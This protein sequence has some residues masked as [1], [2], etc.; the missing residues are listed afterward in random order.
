[1]ASFVRLKGFQARITGDSRGFDRAA[2][3]AAASTR[4]LQKRQDLLRRELRRTT[5]AARTYAKSLLSV[6]SAV[7]VLA[8]GAGLGA[9][10]TRSAEY[11]GV[12]LR[13][14]DGAG[15]L[16]ENLLALRRVAGENFVST[17]LF[18][19]S[20]LK[21]NQRISEAVAGQKQAIDGFKALGISVTDASGNLRSADAILLDF[22]KGLSDA[23][24]EAVARA[25]FVFEE[26]SSQIVPALQMA[27]RHGG[28]LANAYRRATDPTREMFE[29]SKLLGIQFND[30]QEDIKNVGVVVSANVSGPWSEL[31]QIVRDKL[32]DVMVG[33][34]RLLDGVVI[35][36]FRALA[37]NTTGILTTIAAIVATFSRAGAVL[38]AAGGV[39]AATFTK[40]SAYTGLVKGLTAAMWTLV[41]SAAALSAKFIVFTAIFQLF[42]QPEVFIKNF[43]AFGNALLDLFV[44]LGK[45]IG[46]AI[47]NA[48][49]GS[50]DEQIA[51]L[52]A[53]EAVL[54]TQLSTGRTGRGGRSRAE[55]ELRG[56]RAQIAELESET[57]GGLST[58][59]NNVLGVGKDLFLGIDNDAQN[60]GNAVKNLTADLDVWSES[61]RRAAQAR[62]DLANAGTSQIQH[63]QN[64]IPLRAPDIAARAASQRRAINM[65]RFD[66]T[67]RD[68]AIMNAERAR[69]ASMVDTMFSG[70]QIAEMNRQF[71]EAERSIISFS[72]ETRT[73][74]NPVFAQLDSNLNTFFEGILTGTT[75]AGDAFKQLAAQIAQ[76]VLQALILEPLVKSVTGGIGS[77]FGLNIPGRAAGGPV[78]ARSPYVVGERGAE[79]FVPQTSGRIVPNSEMMGGGVVIN[80]QNEF[81]LFDDTG[82]N[83]RMIPIAAQIKDE[84]T[85]GVFDAL[86]RPGAQSV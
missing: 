21:L 33:L 54:T 79:L 66:Y 86:R 83:Q 67:G 26:T 4:R 18:D 32:P 28:E 73:R 45:A 51:D 44:E 39:F 24:I 27:A 31:L 36:S 13:T 6:R 7:A 15:I 53:R 52:K 12:F 56:I 50:V 25:R 35:P 81:K 37:E 14:A 11:A 16:T 43:K 61:A 68:A 80:Q 55:L 58:A 48:I 41:K 72:E 47:R 57:G 9:V 22:I 10:I 77:F 38:G 85:R 46:R 65:E 49:F 62:K 23:G 76:A 84:T 63:Q 5:Y 30:L 71:K 82:F 17:E 29:A 2:K 1:M 74:L 64:L 75:K 60:A 69:R 19:S 70:D 59:F 78:S 40:F 3:A 8:G 34:T 20:L 42:T